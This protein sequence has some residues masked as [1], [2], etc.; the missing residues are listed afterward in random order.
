MT[1]KGRILLADDEETFALSTADLLRAAG[2]EC[3]TAPDG[4]TA[5][6]TGP[7]WRLRPVDQRPRDAR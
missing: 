2:F 6:G 5:P 3:D 7:G 4:G 1:S